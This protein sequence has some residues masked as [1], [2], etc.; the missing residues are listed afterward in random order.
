MAA[1]PM[2]TKKNFFFLQ[3]NILKLFFFFFKLFETSSEDPP[4]GLGLGL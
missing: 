4:F 2:E 3:F 1:I